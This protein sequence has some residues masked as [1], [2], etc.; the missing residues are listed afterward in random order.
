ML[1]TIEDDGVL[2]IYQSVEEAVREVEALDAEDVF[3]Q[4]FDETGRCY[5]VSWIRPNQVGRFTATNGVYTLVPDGRIDV[6]GLKNAIDEAEFVEPE[7]LGPWL[8]ELAASIG[9]R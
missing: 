9:N 1:I 6:N 2:R 5:S 8:R 4:I 3:R 7:S